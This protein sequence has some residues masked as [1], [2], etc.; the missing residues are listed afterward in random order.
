MKGVY[1]AL[2]TPFNEYGQ[3]DEQGFR[4]N[5]R[6]QIAQ[7]VDGIV[8]LGTTG[9]APT[10]SLDEKQRLIEIAVEETKGKKTVM[11][12][13]GSNSTAQTI[14]YTRQAYQLGADMALI[15]V[16]YY[17]RPTQEG[18]YRHFMTIADAVP[19]PICIYNIQA[20]TGQNLET[21]TLSR[22]AEH[23]HL[24]GVKEASGN[25]NQMSDVIEKIIP[26]HPN[27]S[28]MSGDDRLTLPLMS[29]GGHGVISV[30]SNLVPKQLCAL[31]HATQRQDYISARALHYQLMPLFRDAFVET[32][33]SP[34]KTLMNLCGM[35]A[36][37]VRPPLCE[38]QLESTRILQKLIEHYTP[39]G[40]LHGQTQYSSR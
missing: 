36:G 22:L 9:E 6:F 8:P 39:Q 24:I 32:N 35:A 1:T 31:V 29:L 19:I 14:D 34:I 5:I 27:F 37:P 33:P 25:V 23:P 38:L 11:V 10:L 2:I 18:L 13:T 21:A 20:R 4:E 15:V 3:L 28:V 40:I 7:G 26:R 12:G 30:V 16:P 17:N